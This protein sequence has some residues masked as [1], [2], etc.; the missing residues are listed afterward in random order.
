MT[1]VVIGITSSFEKIID[2]VSF[3][4]YVRIGTSHDYI[5]SIEATNAIPFVLAPTHLKSVI[6]GMIS[7][8]DGLILTGGKDI[9]PLMY[10]EEPQIGLGDLS[11]ERDV[12]EKILL[13]EAI[14]QQKPV[15]GIC[16]GMQFINVYFG[17][18]LFQDLNKNDAK[19]LK[20]VHQNHPALITHYVNIKSNSFLATIG[21]ES[22]IGVNSFHHQAINRLG[23]D[24]T[25]TALANDQIIE[26]IELINEKTFIVGVQWHPE[27]MN[28]TD[29]NAQKIFIS[30]IE[31]VKKRKKK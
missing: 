27:M 5:Q 24:L 3:T 22:Q 18:T 7:N 16:R 6:E 4:G 28:K 14:K 25:V 1:K 10:N 19:Y 26:G 31:E 17:G 9:N 23:K 12:F 29:K 15:L 20:H 2:P 11:P 8:I 30:F 13:D 21:L